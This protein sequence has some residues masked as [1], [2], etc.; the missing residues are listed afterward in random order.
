MREEVNPKSDG[1][2]P[3]PSV[4][5]L[6]D[7]HA[8]VDNLGSS[9]EELRRLETE[10]SELEAE[11]ASLKANRDELLR[12]LVLNPRSGDLGSRAEVEQR[13]IQTD[14]KHEVAQAQIDYAA[15]QIANQEE[16][17]H[18]Q[19]PS[20]DQQLARLWR[21]LAQWTHDVEYR[22]VEGVVHKDFRQRQRGT[23]E[24]LVSISTGVIEVVRL[25]FELLPLCTNPLYDT[26]AFK[27][28]EQRSQ[29]IRMV[30]QD[31]ERLLANAE[32]L[33]TALAEPIKLGLTVPAPAPVPV[34]VPA[35]Y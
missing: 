25:K 20:T 28:S 22:A 23:I 30:I 29:T 33:F 13:I 27:W 2:S 19:L 34:K 9:L 18:R 26:P 3:S 16:Q 4:A 14:L 6:H 12:S 24:Q 1:P 32:Q 11:A 15:E 10:R 21:A 35:C 17:L 31:T 5:P 7:Y 8:A